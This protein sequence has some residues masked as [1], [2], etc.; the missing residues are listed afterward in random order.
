VRRNGGWNTPVDVWAEDLPA[1]ITAEKVTAE[2]KDTIVKDNCALDRRL[3]GTNVLLPFHV[4]AGAPPGNYAIRLRAR[5]TMEGRTVDH[6]AEILYKWESAGKVTGPIEKQEL[7]A[8]IIDLPPVVLDPPETLTLSS[9]KPGRLRVLVSRFDGGKTP[10]TLVP[11]PALP[12]VKFENNV[13]PP[14]ANQIELRVTAS[15]AI[16]A[17]QFRLRT[18]GAVSPPVEVKAA[19]GREEEQ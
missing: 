14:G 1:G 5:G 6:I 11:E 15:N 7:L 3:D 13:L 18:A 10:L 12:G 4:A 17:G 16:K 19:G 8:T 2:P 9:G